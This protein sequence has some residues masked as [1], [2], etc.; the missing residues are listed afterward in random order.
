M[1]TPHPLR[2]AVA[3]FATLLCMALPATAAERTQFEAIE[4]GTIDIA[5]WKGKPVLVVN[6]ASRCGFTPQYDEL[7]ALYDTYK[8][9]G[10][11]VLAVPSQDFKQELANDKAVA[12]FCEVNFDLTLPMT[13][14]TH[15][16]GPDA[17]PFYKW[18]AAQAGFVPGW[19]FNKVLIGPDGR[20]HGFWGAPV[21]P[22]SDAITKQVELFLPES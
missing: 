14:I 11:M 3:L 17:H 7:Q 1:S 10:L 6:T 9:R 22:M 4:G 19:N 13:T 16:K 15:V 21:K 2:K 5:D 18:V 12:E 20:V 8:D